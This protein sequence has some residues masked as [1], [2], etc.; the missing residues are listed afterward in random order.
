[1]SNLLLLSPIYD[2][3]AP[4]ITLWSLGGEVHDN[5]LLTRI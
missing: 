3:E 2:K 5:R 1:M 4:S